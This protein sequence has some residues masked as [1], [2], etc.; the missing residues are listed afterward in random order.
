[1]DAAV[2]ADPVPLLRQR[3]IDEF[4]ISEQRLA[5]IEAEIEAQVDDAM[6]FAFASDLPALSENEID[7]FAEVANV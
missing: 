4:G 7:V 2:A 5:E 6:N 3:L 1:M